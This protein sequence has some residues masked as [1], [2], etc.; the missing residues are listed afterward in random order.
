MRGKNT[1]CMGKIHA[2]LP[3]DNNTKQSSNKAPRFKNIF[4][5]GSMLQKLQKGSSSKGESEKPKKSTSFIHPSQGHLLCVITDAICAFNSSPP[6]PQFPQE[7]GFIKPFRI[8]LLLLEF[9][10]VYFPP[11][12]D[13]SLKTQFPPWTWHVARQINPLSTELPLAVS[14][15]YRR[16]LINAVLSPCSCVKAA[17]AI[18]KFAGW[19]YK[20][21]G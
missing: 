19:G 10:V 6:C 16:V 13:S 4:M 9:L 3:F 21:G 8:R 7:R 20:N 17:D 15:I 1:K 14:C 12:L 18:D 2:P 11:F 5:Y